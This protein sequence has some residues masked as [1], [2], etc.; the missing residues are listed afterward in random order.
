MDVFEELDSQF[1]VRARF[2]LLITIKTSD[3][4]YRLQACERGQDFLTG[5]GQ[6]QRVFLSMH[7]IEAMS[8]PVVQTSLL[9][10][11][12]ALDEIELPQRVLLNR[13][14]QLVWWLGLY[15]GH[16]RFK[17]HRETFYLPG[18]NLR[19]LVLVAVDN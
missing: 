6:N 3:E 1:E 13:K 14:N 16:L 15:E 17:D 4:E 5:L 18:E 9:T 19:N 10:L 12:Q 7:A 11:A 8:Q 2:P